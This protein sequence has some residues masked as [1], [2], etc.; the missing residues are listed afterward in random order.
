MATKLVTCPGSGRP[1]GIISGASNPKVNCP[2]CQK[3][4]GVMH[5]GK[6]RKHMAMRKI[7]KG[8]R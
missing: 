7:T 2:S 3:R 6:I 1:A 5:T 8:P 4:V